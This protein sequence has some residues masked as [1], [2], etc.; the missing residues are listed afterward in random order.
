M[1][2]PGEGFGLHL[3]GGHGGGHG[4]ARRAGVTMAAMDGFVGEEGMRVEED[5]GGGD[6]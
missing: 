3:S 1:P 5:R 2:S 6:V 4:N